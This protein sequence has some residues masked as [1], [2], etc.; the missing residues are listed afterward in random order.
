MLQNQKV[1]FEQLA[2]KLNVR[3]PEDWLQITSKR[4]VQEGGRFIK[5]YYNGSVVKALE[6]LY[7]E[8][9]DVWQRYK[10]HGYWKLIDNQRQFFDKLATVLSINRP[11]DWLHVKNKTIVSHGGQFIYSYYDGSILQGTIDPVLYLSYLLSIAISLPRTSH[12]M[13]ERCREYTNQ[14]H[15]PQI[16]WILERNKESAPLF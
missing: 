4:V 15:A 16:V 9:Q 14:G 6:L 7:P 12:I 3:K 11:E 2:T 1:F 8:H 10:Q 13:A 5:Q